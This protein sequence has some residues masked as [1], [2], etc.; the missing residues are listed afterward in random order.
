[1]FYLLNVVV[2]KKMTQILLHWEFVVYNLYFFQKYNINGKCSDM[3]HA[4][5]PRY[6]IKYIIIYD[7]DHS[8]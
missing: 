4:T 7:I 2:N 3:Q 8:T 1:M 6:D 5:S